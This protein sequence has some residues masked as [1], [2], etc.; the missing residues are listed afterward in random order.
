LHNERARWRRRSAGDP[1]PEYDAAE[2]AFARASELDPRALEA[3]M[4]RGLTRTFRAEWK[5]GRGIDPLPDFAGAESDF[6]E[7]LRS[8]RH[9]VRPWEMRGQ[10]GFFRGIYRM[11]RNAD[12]LED[13]T[14]AEED[15]TEALRVNP[16]NPRAMAYRGRTRYR[17]A[18]LREKNGETAK[19]VQLL[20]AAG[21]DLARAFELNKG[22]ESE[23][24][25]ELTEIRKRLASLAP[26]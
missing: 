13:F 7:A 12:A 25:G 4:D 1:L 16:M 21:E 2:K 22:L 11:G 10:V 8:L 15:F 23:M 3:L 17:L 26:K 9:T 18:G 14:Q 5:S 6:S 24:G 19:V 20:G